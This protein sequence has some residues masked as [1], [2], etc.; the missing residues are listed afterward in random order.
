M[1]LTVR[2]LDGHALD[3]EVD[4][5]GC[6]KDIRRVLV[7]QHGLAKCALYLQ[8]RQLPIKLS[9]AE[10]NLQDG[11]T[12]RSWHPHFD[13]QQVTL[14]HLAA[15]VADHQQQLQQQQQQDHSSNNLQP[16]STAH[17][18]GAVGA[19]GLVARPTR[20]LARNRS[21]SSCEP[22][23]PEQLLEHLQSLRWYQGQVVHVQHTR[24]RLPRHLAPSLPLAPSTRAALAARGIQQ[25]FVHQAAAVDALCCQRKHV[26]VATSTA[27]GK[28]LCYNVPM[29]E[30]LAADRDACCLLLFPTKAL[31]QDQLRVLRQLMADA[32]GADAPCVQ[33]YDG[34]TPHPQR[35]AIRDHA[36]LLITNPDMLHQSI[37]PFHSN[38]SRLLAKLAYVVVDEGHAYRGVFGCHAALVL[39]RLRRLCS[40]AY[41]SSPLFV[42]TSAT[43][44]NPLEH[45]ALLLGV[46]PEALL[47][48]DEDGSPHGPKEFVLWNPPLTAQAQQAVGEGGGGVV[49]S[50]TEQRVGGVAASGAAAAAP[51]AAL[52]PKMQR[53]MA[54]TLARESNAARRR[55]VALNAAAGVTEEEWTAAEQQLHHLANAD[56]D[57]VMVDHLEPARGNGQPRPLPKQQQ[58]QQQQ[59]QQAKGTGGAP[60]AGKLSRKTRQVASEALAAVQAAAETFSMQ[61]GRGS[62]VMKRRPAHG[63]MQPPAAAQPS[64]RNTPSSMPAAAPP[65]SSSRAG[66]TTA[67]A[68]AGAAAAL[69]PDLQRQIEEALPPRG[70]FKEL[71][72][73]A[74]TP[75]DQRRESPIVEM[76]LLLAEAVMHG[77]R[78]IAFCK[79]RKLCELIS[80]Y[81]RENLKA[82]APHKA[83]LVKVYRA[84]YS[85]AE[86]RQLEADLHSG[87]LTAVAATNALEL[88]IDVGSLDLTLHLGFPGSVAS[89]W[90]QA[91]RA[92]RRSQAS[93]SLYVAFD[94]PLDQH[95]MTHPQA[96]FARPIECVQLDPCNAIV[97]NS[98]L[99]CAAKELPLLPSEDGPL[100][101][102]AQLR[103]ALQQLRCASLLGRHP[104]DPPHSE[105]LHYTGRAQNPAADVSLRTIDPERFVIWNAADASVLEEIEA[106]MAFY[107]IYDGAIYMYQGR[108][109]ICTSLSLE[110]RVAQVKPID[111]RWY[112][113]GSG[114]VFDAIDLFLPDTQFETQACYMRLPPSARRACD[115]AG[116]PFREAVH[117][118]S[119]ALLNVLPLYM[120]CNSTDM[121]TECDNPYDTRFRPERLLLYDKHP[122]GIGL[123]AQATPLFPELL[124]QALELVQRC[125]CRYVKGCP[126]CAQHLDC[127]NYN[128]VLNKAGA[129]LVLQAALEQEAAVAE[130][131]A[132]QH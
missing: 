72:G 1:Q 38:F 10:L 107:E 51:A 96:L 66:A 115:A 18:G 87:A 103:A 55:G 35:A 93:A 28:S 34:D 88:G 70:Q 99:V 77:L 83:G 124:Q 117:A 75:L 84:G 64:N 40:R 41:A 95:F 3:V 14:Q 24:A 98:H 121:G 92:G 47:L 20:T 68:A 16:G 30:A 127:K 4:A 6:V 126:C 86:R 39:R 2:T 49:L 105:A 37:L 36:Q 33:V 50:R 112:T 26:V 9:L 80:A 43:I 23:R 74:G 62:R 8:A 100:F 13:E 46:G 108:T 59:Q 90:Q 120:V 125:A 132:G 89:L 101:G 69:Q 110:T 29:L 116:I 67:A 76:S 97:L 111:V 11:D 53:E 7:E 85:P 22:L 94:G 73:A 31:A 128:A 52:S 129:V 19:A 113:R 21:C 118:A 27:S 15:A 78:T 109:Y 42:V 58:Q 65:G 54:R 60:A 91:G 102:E 106:N 104:R 131:R 5:A 45:A 123:A 71:Y 57:V 17:N 12:L 63:V 56:D 81:T 44:A 130:A 48:V 25:L 114:Q 61:K 32:F 82:C 79:S 119:H 122:G